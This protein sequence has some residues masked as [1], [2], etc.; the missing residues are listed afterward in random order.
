MVLS[1]KDRLVY[2]IKDNKMKLRPEQTVKNKI[3][4]KSIWKI[5][6]ILDDIEEKLE[7]MQTEE[8]QLNT[9]DYDLNKDLF[10]LL[11]LIDMA[12]KELKK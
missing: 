10:K 8:Y 7:E 11:R 2:N 12:R 1:L 4:L 6:S 5:V 9:E 3:T